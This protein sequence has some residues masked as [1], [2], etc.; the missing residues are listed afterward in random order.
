MQYKV[1]GI[2]NQ[3]G[4]WEIQSE[5]DSFVFG[6]FAGCMADI[7]DA[8]KQING[9]SREGQLETHSLDRAARNVSVAVRKLMFDGNGYLFKECV[10]AR[11]HALKDPKGR[12]KKG[13]RGDVLVERIEGM[14][15]HYTVVDSEEQKTFEAP[16]YEHR[17]VVNPLY[18][19]RRTGKEQYQLE[20][21]FEF[22]EPPIKYGR[23]MNLKVLQVGDAVLSAERILQLLAS[24]EGAHVEAN[25]LTSLNASLPVDVKLPKRPKREDELYRKGTWITFGG[26][27]YL[28]IFTLLVGVYLVN[29]MKE[30]LKRLPAHTVKRL[31]NTHLLDS[32][33][34]SPSRIATPELLLKKDFNIGMVLQSVGDAFEL[35]GEHDKPGITT[36][37]IPGWT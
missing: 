10:E 35:V 33:L 2:N 32:I 23:W 20:D 29:M 16:A 34:Q 36:I 12:P 1:S 5:V 15:I 26:V 30:T 27:S 18:G 8:I 17:T 9:L 13:L 11:L 22:S 6:R 31:H 19:L 25:E 28:H 37:Q 3:N 24:Y 21:P 4:H 14:S 7:A